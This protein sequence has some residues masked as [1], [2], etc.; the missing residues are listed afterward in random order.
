MSDF[1]AEDFAAASSYEIGNRKPRID[2]KTMEVSVTPEMLEKI[3]YSMNN[4]IIVPD[5]DSSPEVD[6]TM[7]GI[8]PHEEIQLVLQSIIDA[9]TYIRY[10]NQYVLVLRAGKKTKGTKLVGQVKNHRNSVLV[11]SLNDVKYSTIA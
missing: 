9:E 3:K 6:T 1:E 5:G 11:S 4:A 8:T 7:T 2:E 10:A